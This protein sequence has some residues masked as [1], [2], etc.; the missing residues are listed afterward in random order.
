MSGPCRPAAQRAVSRV[1]AVACSDCSG[2]S[3]SAGWSISAGAHRRRVVPRRVTLVSVSC[4]RA[5]PHWMGGMQMCWPWACWRARQMTRSTMASWRPLHGVARSWRTLTV[6]R[7]QLSCR[8]Y[9][10]RGVFEALPWRAAWRRS[11]SRMV[12]GVRGGCSGSGGGWRG[13]LSRSSSSMSMYGWSWACL[14]GL[15]GARWSRG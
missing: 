10:P 14:V 2:W 9:Q 4:V 3:G 7:I 8:R 1:G 15:G 5:W 12:V 11:E 6:S 13:G